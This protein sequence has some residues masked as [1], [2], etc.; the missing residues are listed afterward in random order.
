ASITAHSDRAAPA[1]AVAVGGAAIPGYMANVSLAVS[2]DAAVVESMNPLKVSVPLMPAGSTVTIELTADAQPGCGDDSFT[3]SITASATNAPP[4]T[5]SGTFGV[6]RAVRETC[7][8]VDNDCDGHVDG[9]GLCDDGDRCTVDTCR[10]TGGCAHEAIANCRP[11]VEICGDCIDNDGDGLVDWEDP[12]CCEQ[13]L[14]LTPKRVMLKRPAA[15]GRNRMRVKAIYSQFTPAGFDPT[16]DDTSVQI[17]DGTG[18]VVRA[19]G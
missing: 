8:G 18:P 17:A 12:D 15:K 3:E 19:T 16:R 13:L 9:E 1:Q 6:D 2:S 10:G 5:Y 7:D 4:V 14:A 11:P